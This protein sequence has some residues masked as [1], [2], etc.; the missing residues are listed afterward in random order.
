MIQMGWLDNNRVLD[1]T[2]DP[3]VFD[4][5]ALDAPS[6]TAGALQVLMFTDVSDY[7]AKQYYFALR[8]RIG[9][10]SFHLSA[11]YADLLNIHSNSEAGNGESRFIRAIGLGSNF[12]TRVRQWRVDVLSLAN[13]C[14]RVQLA[15]CSDPATCRYQWQGT[16][17]SAC[18]T[19]CGVGS[20]TRSVSCRDSI[21]N[22][23]VADDWCIINQEIPSTQVSSSV[24]RPEWI[25]TPAC[26]SALITLK[27]F[28]HTDMHCRLW[29]HVFV[30][31]WKLEHVLSSL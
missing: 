6:A 20:Q 11:T 10:S 28:S 31:H 8:A 18:S 22:A 16:A 4:L 14:V 19:T 12:V 15:P 17:W 13:N 26:V 30:E 1:V 7:P 2:N 5:C 23:V 27:R 3:G 29:H 21:T 9:Y 25:D 24:F